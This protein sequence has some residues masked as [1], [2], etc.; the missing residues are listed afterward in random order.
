MFT[1]GAIFLRRALVFLEAVRAG[2]HPH[3]PWL[4][5]REEVS[6]ATAHR[7]IRRLRDEY[8]APL[9]Y[10]D[11][12]RGWQLT[13]GDWSF[14][15][16]TLA[17]RRE[18]VALALG[19]SLC[20]S[21]DDPELATATETLRLRLAECLRASR[22]QLERVL[23]AFRAERTDQTLL[24]EPVLLDAILAAAEGNALTFRYR[25]PW[26]R[27]ERERRVCPLAVRQVDGVPYLLAFEKSAPRVFNLGFVR[28]LRVTDQRFEPGELPPWDGGSET[29]GAWAGPQARRIRVRIGSP[30]AEYYAEQRWHA[31][32]VDRWEQGDLVRTFQAH[33]SPEVVRR[34]LSLG[35]ALVAV[36]PEEL[37]DEVRQGARRILVALDDG[38]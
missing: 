1:D 26:K 20:G 6:L 17:Q 7:V 33:V 8:G 37:R 19:V 27:E 10:S 3:A 23:A 15:P 28:D 36:E 30:D 21:L 22:A 2:R 14:L 4:A 12:D 5:E 11:A 35:P 29:F 16:A 34:V 9:M 31:S 38:A 32:Q 18:L 25:S 24:A 13:N